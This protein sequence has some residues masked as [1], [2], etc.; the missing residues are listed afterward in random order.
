MFSF[1]PKNSIFNQLEPWWQIMLNFQ[2][3]YYA[4]T[5]KINMPKKKNPERK[6]KENKFLLFFPTFLWFHANE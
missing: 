1:P 4:V 3:V 6:G 5:R 2:A